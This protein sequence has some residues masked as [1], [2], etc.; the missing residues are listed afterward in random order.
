MEYENDKCFSCEYDLFKNNAEIRIF[1]G[2]SGKKYNVCVDCYYTQELSP[3]CKHCCKIYKDMDKHKKTKLHKNNKLENKPFELTKDENIEFK[4]ND[5]SYLKT[6]EL[7][8]KN[9]NLIRNNNYVNL[10][11]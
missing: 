1:T 8:I 6:K 4:K 7:R 5:I 9:F 10:D 11:I 3:Y 2:T